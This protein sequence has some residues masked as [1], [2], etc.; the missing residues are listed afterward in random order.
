MDLDFVIEEFYYLCIVTG[1]KTDI[2]C[3]WSFGPVSAV[4]FAAIEWKFR[5]KTN[6]ESSLAIRILNINVSTF[7]PDSRREEWNSTRSLVNL[8]E[9][10]DLLDINEFEWL[11]LKVTWRATPTTLLRAEGEAG[12]RFKEGIITCCTADSTVALQRCG[13]TSIMLLWKIQRNKQ[14]HTAKA[15]FCVFCIH[16]CFQALIAFSLF[17]LR[18][19]CECFVASVRT[20]TTELLKKQIIKW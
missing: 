4:F 19:S 18:V 12:T 7:K 6:Q 5:N 15:D 14:T 3:Y 13:A 2:Y 16:F 9:Q 20:R 8:W 17:K 1:L 11:M 10:F